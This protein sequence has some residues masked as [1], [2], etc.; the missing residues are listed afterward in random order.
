MILKN[1]KI[2]H[3]HGLFSEEELT[4]NEFEVNLVASYEPLKVPV[5]HLQETVDYTSLYTIVK[6]RMQKRTALLETIAT[7]IVLDIMRKFNN[8]QQVN[9][10]IHKLNAPIPNFQGVVGVSFEL[11]RN[12][13]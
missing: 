13:L 11:N 1:V 8:V 2:Q 12:N 10:S 6:D 4:G 9:I 5:L 3:T 7:E